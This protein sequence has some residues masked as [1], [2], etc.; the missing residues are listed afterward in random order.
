MNNLIAIS[1]V[2]RTAPLVLVLT[3]LGASGAVTAQSVGQK[4]QPQSSW[5]HHFNSGSQAF[6]AKD[7]PAAL[8]SFDRAYSIAATQGKP[9]ATL[10]YNRA[11]T[12]YKLQRYE[13][14]TIAFAL[15]IPP[16]TPSPDDRQWA[17]LGR[18]NLG[19]IARDQRQYPEA[20]RRFTELQHPDTNGRLRELARRQLATLPSATIPTTAA[21]KSSMLL[22][23]GLTRDDNAS[24]LADELSSALSQSEDT[25]LNALGYGQYYV[26]GNRG[27]G[28]RIYGL[29]QARRYQEYQSFNS[30]VFGGGFATEF[31]PASWTYDLG[32]RILQSKLDGNNLSTQY[33]LLTRAMGKQDAAGNQRKSHGH[34]DLGYQVSF[35]EAASNFAYIE[36]WQHQFRLARQQV[37]GPV[38]AIPSIS[39]ET[40]DR[41]NRVTDSGFYS[42][43][44]DILTAS[45]AIRW[46]AT[47][48]WRLYTQLDWADAN[49]AGTNRLVDLG[50]EEKAQSREYRRTQWLAGARY[51]IGKQ[52][53]LKAEYSSATSD[54]N[55]ALYSYD[56]N[57]FS[58]KLDYG[59]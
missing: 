47:P 39:W 46:E 4:P 2:A 20:K 25:Y 5:Q 53:G 15:L 40:N 49:Y 42:Y 57:V 10:I 6:K 43:S 3:L 7:Y 29:L 41:D 23:L 28:T 38:T 44:P 33:T 17:D 14:A 54:D 1:R 59:W 50:R 12:L 36:G 13:E 34:W 52:W 21:T 16:A 19:M 11:V 37:F 56:K 31:T 51:R 45:L 35:I 48:E 22:S 9:G 8:Q 55:F 32:G 30:D 18:Y 26:A 58:L 27:Q 24:S